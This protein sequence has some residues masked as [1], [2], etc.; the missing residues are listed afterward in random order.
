[1]TPATGSPSSRLARNM[2]DKR[3]RIFSA[4]SE[5]FA[6]R[7][8]GAVSTQ[9]V[10]DRADV[11]A[12]TLF[13]YASSKGELLLMVFN[14]QLRE[15]LSEGR[16]RAESEPDTVEA[17]LHLVEPILL[18]ATEAG[19]NSVVYQREL[20]FG[21]PGEKYRDQGLGLIV[22][23]E[24]RIASRLGAEA[25][26]LG[27]PPDQGRAALASAAIFA[28]THLAV[29]RNSTGTH[30]ERDARA[31]L[32]EQVRLIVQGYLAD[33]LEPDRRSRAITSQSSSR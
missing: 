6:E 12:G 25:S 33:L 22:D 24:T 8:F 27:L 4:A 32:H 17:I 30:P 7:G 18:R 21:A 11:A 29:A 1:M 19:E 15:A 14:E 20:L 3:D 28:V 31:D 5:L 23:L 13:R 9:E 2:Q 26:S 16:R 10:S